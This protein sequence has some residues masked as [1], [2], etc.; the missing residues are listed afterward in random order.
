MQAPRDGTV[1]LKNVSFQIKSGQKV[2][3]CGRT[4][5]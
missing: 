3:V 1:A 4:G 5:R 2:G